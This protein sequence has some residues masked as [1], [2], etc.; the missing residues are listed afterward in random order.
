MTLYDS[1][2]EPDFSLAAAG[3]AAR[4]LT[5]EQGMM[6]GFFREKQVI[7]SNGRMPWR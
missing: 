5:I 2:I 4:S 6:R 1:G 7:K 3:K